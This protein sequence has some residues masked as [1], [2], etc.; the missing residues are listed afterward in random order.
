VNQQEPETAGKL[1]TT[2]VP[3]TTSE[4]SVA[5]TLTQLQSFSDTYDTIDYIYIVDSTHLVG[6][7]S[8][9]ELLIAK[10]KTLIANIMIRNVAYVHQNT[11]QE[12]VAQLALAQNI[13]AV[14]VL[15][16]NEEFIG[17]VTSDVILRTLRDEHN[18]DI[19]KY[20]GI[21]VS[22][23]ERLSQFTMWQHL[24]SRLP[25]LVIGLGGGIL[26]AWVVE[27]YSYAMESE[28]VLAA[29]IPAI[30]YIADSVGSQTQMVFVRSLATQQRTSI[31]KRLGKEL[32]I[33]T[34]VGAILSGLIGII[35]WLW[36]GKLAI[37]LILAISVL[38][39]VYF[40]VI[41]ALI[42]PW[43]FDKAGKDPALASGPL[44][45]VIRDV[46]SLA[47]YFFVALQI[48]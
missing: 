16:M 37:T 10:P 30:V 47:I 39:T 33:A 18:E 21:N 8:L 32:V 48:L 4:S 34:F 28:L 7:V 19:L 2:A 24:T 38:L 11:D 9:H 27:K 42:L 14:P 5:D 25:W 41:V 29:F 13:K 31:L 26:A 23:N 35:S 45:T 3:K 17:V 36:L 15:S 1:A 12:N 6:V 40:S 20:A 43:V 46:S 44:A 22:A